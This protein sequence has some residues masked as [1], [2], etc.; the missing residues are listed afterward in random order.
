MANRIMEWL[1]WTYGIG[2]ELYF[3]TTAAYEFGDRSPWTARYHFGGNGDGTLFLPGR[4]DRIGGSTHI[5]IE[6]VRLKLI[7]EGLEDYEY[8]AKVTQLGDRGFAN[9]Q[10]RTLV[11]NTYTWSHDPAALYAARRALAQRIVALQGSEA[12]PQLA[13]PD[14]L[15]P[16]PEPAPQP[17]TG[18][19]P[20]QVSQSSA[21]EALGGAGCGMVATRSDAAV[22]LS[23]LVVVLGAALVSV[24]RAPR[25]LTPG[26]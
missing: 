24:L 1:S 23:W 22:D 18:D 15:Q 6:T 3:H 16:A 11:T 2:G 9:A 17:V 5:P 20:A 4:P 10:A 7:R 8:L 25:V 12:P 13:A 14:P 21:G 26:V 19:Q